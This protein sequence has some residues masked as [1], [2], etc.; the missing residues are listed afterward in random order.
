MPYVKA[1]EHRKMLLELKMLRLYKKNSETK[2]KVV[3]NNETKTKVVKKIVCLD[4]DNN[5]LVPKAQLYREQIRRKRAEAKVREHQQIIK[6]LP[7]D[8]G[9]YLDFCLLTKNKF[10]EKEQIIKELIFQNN[11]LRTKLKEL[12]ENVSIRGNNNKITI[13]SI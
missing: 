6:S 4:K 10:E 12:L 8:Q 13:R 1:D 5:E 7:K 2:T 9:E 11:Q 3:K